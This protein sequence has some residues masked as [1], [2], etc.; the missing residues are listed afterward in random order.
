MSNQHPRLIPNSTRTDEPSAQAVQTGSHQE[1]YQKRVC[2]RTWL[3]RLTCLMSV[4]LKQEVKNLQQVKL[5][6][7]LQFLFLRKLI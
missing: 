5:K 3:L 2:L 4:I 6:L 7:S 1:Q